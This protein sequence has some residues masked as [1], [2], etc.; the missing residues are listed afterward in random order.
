MTT[1]YQRYLND[2]MEASASCGGIQFPDPNDPKYQDDPDRSS[3]KYSLQVL[4]RDDAN[5]DRTNAESRKRLKEAADRIDYLESELK[6][7][8][9]DARSI[10][11]DA[12]R[13]RQ[14]SEDRVA[15]LEKINTQ[16]VETHNN[17]LMVYSRMNKEN[18]DLRSAL[19]DAISLLK[20]EQIEKGSERMRQ[21]I[22]EL[23]EVL[24][25]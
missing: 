24:Y 5:F 1:G 7:C 4:L 13:L 14:Q 18:E 23:N 12:L 8:G 17:Q 9:D 15:E 6:R 11:A 21:E 3:M 2:L 22:R 19:R 25:P 20:D 10:I 16:L